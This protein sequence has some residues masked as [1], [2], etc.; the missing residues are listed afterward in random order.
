MT[1][2]AH[3]HIVGSHRLFSI[4]SR[5]RNLSVCR[6]ELF[7]RAGKKTVWLSV[8]RTSAHSCPH[9][10]IPVNTRNQPFVTWLVK[11]SWRPMQLIRH[12]EL[13]CRCSGQNFPAPSGLF[14]NRDCCN[15]KVTWRCL[16]GKKEA[17]SGSTVTYSLLRHYHA[18]CWSIWLSL[19]M[20]FFT[21]TIREAHKMSLLMPKILTKCCAKARHISLPAY[22]VVHALLLLLGCHVQ[23][24]F[25]SDRSHGS[26]QNR[27]AVVLLDTWLQ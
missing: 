18:F 3:A 11:H 2:H 14:F 20:L 1:R 21:L 9:P 12:D 7:R 13:R 5:V 25:I 8:W 4:L 16:A 24:I 19:F 17:L 15:N 10:P 6:S 26:E 23:V 27:I 22:R